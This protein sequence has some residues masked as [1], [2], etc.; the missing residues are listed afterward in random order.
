MDE[1]KSDT[2][3]S[4]RYKYVITYVLYTCYFIYVSF[5]KIYKLIYL[6]DIS[7]Y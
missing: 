6:N 1:K 5:L 2:E 4:R 7:I 3:L